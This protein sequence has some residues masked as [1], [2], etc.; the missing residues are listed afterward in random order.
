MR[1]GRAIVG[2]AGIAA[3]ASGAAI[4]RPVTVTVNDR[5]LNAAA[6]VD[7]G[8][9]FVPMR[10][11]F[12]ALG[13]TVAYDPRTQTIVAS[14]ASHRVLLR[15]GSRLATVDG[16]SEQI[17]A[18]VR[19]IAL[20]TYVP[21]RFVSEALGAIVGF[22]GQHNIVAVATPSGTARVDGL[23]PP[24]D[25]SVATGYPA[26]GASLVGE[27]ARQSE[28]HL[29]IDGNDVTSLATFDGATIAYIPRTS[30]VQGWHTA[31]FSG[32]DTEGNQF[33]QTWR[34]QTTVAGSSEE[35]APES[36]PGYVMPYQ[37]YTSGNSVYRAG[38]WMHFVLVA[39]PGGSAFLQLCGLGF[40]YPFWNGGNGTMYQANIPAPV[41]YVIP[42]CQVTAVY[43]AWNGRQTY[44]PY[45][46]FV[47]IYTRPT[48]R[49]TP[50]P[51]ATPG[52]RYTE[53]IGRRP[54][55]EPTVPARLPQAPIATSHPAPVPTLRPTPV[56]TLRPTPVP[57]L[58]PAPVLTLHP[59][60]MPTLHP[61]PVPVH[62][63]HP[64]QTPN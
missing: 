28:I 15:I 53:P 2:A 51:T 58:H 16:H 18:P 26:I 56:P 34:F 50:K 39:P 21:L 14:T 6:L 57:T 4:A 33:E 19:V 61:A 23:N 52:V 44:V 8:H 9:I 40:E 48:P 13:A 47:G 32:V 63:P 35:S 3:F 42:S 22:D 64:K 62:A 41:G 31:S 49:P 59:K 10:A 30:L 60:S 12:E 54:A 27:T 38:D 46:V 11:I 29:R 45:P 36:M 55:P 37:F 1:I 17:E 20:T 24:S 5:P 25:A 43:T 7:A